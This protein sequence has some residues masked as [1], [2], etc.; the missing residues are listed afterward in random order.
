MRKE[1]FFLRTT[2]LVLDYRSAINNIPP[3]V[4]DIIR[5]FSP[6]EGIMILLRASGIYLKHGRSVGL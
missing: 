2:Y 1:D 4:H 5:V 3:V 6:G